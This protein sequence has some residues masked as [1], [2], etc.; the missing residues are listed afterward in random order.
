[1]QCQTSFNRKEDLKEGFVPLTSTLIVFIQLEAEAAH[2]WP[3]DSG[4]VGDGAGRGGRGVNV[5]VGAQVGRAVH[6]VGSGHAQVAAVLVH[7]HHVSPAGLGN[8]PTF[9]DVCNEIAKV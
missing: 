2:E 7:T 8:R 5:G 3:G 9:I 6:R 1:M 4:V